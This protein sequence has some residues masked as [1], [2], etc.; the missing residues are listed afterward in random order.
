MRLCTLLPTRDRDARAL[1]GRGLDVELVRE[2]ARAVE[3][4]AEASACRI[5]VAQREIDVD[6]AGAL[7]FERQAQPDPPGTIGDA[8]DAHLAPAAVD[9]GVARQ[10][11]GSG[12][13]LGLLDQ[14]EAG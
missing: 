14:A 7:I 10:L 6:D 5:A 4:E 2:L 9:H 13:D 1:T 3:A 8:L 12:H 11:A